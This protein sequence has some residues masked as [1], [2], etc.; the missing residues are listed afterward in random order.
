VS[1]DKKLKYVGTVPFTINNEVAGNR[2]L[3]VRA[4]DGQIDRM[5]IIQQE[6][7]LP[8]S[9]D[10]YKYS[11]TNPAELGDSEYQ[12]SVIMDDNDARIREEPGKEADLTRQFLAAH[13]YVLEP[14]IVMSRFARPVDSPH[15]HEII[16][17]CFEN[18]SSYEHKLADF[19]EGTSSPQ[20][21]NI[22][23]RVDENC[24]KAFRVS[25]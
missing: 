23:Q 14:E 24:R 7:F 11:I 22:K 13:G 19:P 5:F 18:L 6:G 21:Q 10:A 3:F 2:F 8:S 1:V 25:H 15:K 17:F 9:S 20:K 16:F 12:H 4:R